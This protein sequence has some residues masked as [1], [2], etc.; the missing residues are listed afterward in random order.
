V[1]GSIRG[2]VGR[3]SMIIGVLHFELLVHGA[4]SLKDKRRV[5]RS[6][7]DRLHREHQAA[8]AEVGSLEMLN[9]ASLALAVV[10]TD[11]AAIGATLDR[12]TEKLR[13]LRDAE[14]GGARREL[15]RPGRGAPGE[16]APIDEAALAQELLGYA[17]D[18]EEA[19]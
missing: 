2:V 1:F 12:I 11:G 10:G 6:V 9:V 4:E 14:L 19:S 18:E 17:E 16:E 8:V 5:V 7:K 3:V 13:T 15:I